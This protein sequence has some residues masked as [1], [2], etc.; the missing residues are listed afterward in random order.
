MMMTMMIQYSKKLTIQFC[1]LSHTFFFFLQLF[2]SFSMNRPGGHGKISAIHLSH[3]GSQVQSLDIK[4]TITR[5]VD[6]NVPADWVDPHTE[7]QRTGRARRPVEEFSKIQEFQAPPMKRPRNKITLRKLTGTAKK[8]EEALEVTVASEEDAPPQH[9]FAYE[10][11]TSVVSE[12]TDGPVCRTAAASAAT[13]SARSLTTGQVKQIDTMP[14]PPPPHLPPVTSTSTRILPAPSSPPNIARASTLGGGQFNLSSLQ[15]RRILEVTNV[16][17]YQQQQQQQ[18]TG[19]VTLKQVYTQ[20]VQ[21]A[22]NFIDQVVAN[23]NPPSSPTT[24]T[25]HTTGIPS[26]PPQP[27]AISPARRQFVTLFHELLVN[28]DG[29]V[30][31]EDV[32]QQVNQL[33]K[34]QNM[35][36]TFESSQVEAYIEALCKEDKVMRSEGLLYTI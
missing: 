18:S 29:V 22:R 35:D 10:D 20:Q 11:D 24:T 21:E 3:D 1:S 6:R 25:K 4:Y 19:H 34:Q 26:P 36:H 27:A 33:A 13:V 9:I 17:S 28:T 16:S 32:T 8:K 2:L 7:L 14:P 12:L 30:Q 23:A 31:E 5:G 15:D